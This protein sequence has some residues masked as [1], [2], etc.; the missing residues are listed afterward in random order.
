MISNL[1]RRNESFFLFPSLSWSSC[2]L[3]LALQPS[4][5]QSVQPILSQ[6]LFSISVC[7]FF[8][9]Q[10]SISHVDLPEES[11]NEAMEVQVEEP[12]HWDDLSEVIMS[13]TALSFPWK[14]SPRSP[15]C[16]LS[17]GD[18][19]AAGHDWEYTGSSRL[20][21]FSSW[22][23]EMMAGITWSILESSTSEE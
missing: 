5:F 14:I 2:M 11:H 8:P 19:A 20:F 16:M 4:H 7:L 21:E 22:H 1:V 6:K 23:D 18:D 10:C 3:T 17:H 13:C 12:H 9:Q 15:G